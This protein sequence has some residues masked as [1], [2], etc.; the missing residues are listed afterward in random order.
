MNKWEKKLGFGMICA[1]TLLLTACSGAEEQGHIIDDSRESIQE[2]SA[3]SNEAA[4]KKEES[5]EAETAAAEDKT[6]ADPLEGL[7]VLYPGEWGKAEDYELVTRFLEA[8]ETV[9]AEDVRMVCVKDFDGDNNTEAFLFAGSLEDDIFGTYDGV[10]WFITG[11]DYHAVRDTEER[12]WGELG[13][14]LDFGDKAYFYMSEYY[15]TGS[16]SYAWEVQNGVEQETAFSRV[17]GIH[18]LMGDDFQ[19]TISAYDNFEMTDD[20]PGLTIGHTW[21]PY[22]FYYDRA[23]GEVREYGA[24]TV[25]PYSLDNIFGE[26]L[27][28]RL[29]DY[30][31]VITNAMYRSN[32]ILTINCAFPAEDGIQYENLNYDC[33]NKVFIDAMMGDEDPVMGSSFGGIYEHAICPEIA[34]FP[35]TDEVDFVI[36]DGKDKLAAMGITVAWLSDTMYDAD[37]CEV[38]NISDSDYAGEILF[39]TNETIGEFKVLGLMMTDVDEQGKITYSVENLYGKKELRFGTPLVLRLAFMGDIPNNGFSFVDKE[40]KTR[41]FAFSIS[42]YDGSLVVT[43]F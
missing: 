2:Q 21:K 43:E 5:K 7:E 33:K 30:E 28:D 18:S 31:N 9:K 24:S 42:G 25:S 14:L 12:S 38:I 35:T 1:V 20:M 16:A 11:S 3:G 15:A 39:N 29:A 8:E 4:D 23:A 6:I 41:Q 13:S 17:G 26:N 36:E 37:Y 10:L 19:I 22:Y 27:W 32:G 34:A 40:G